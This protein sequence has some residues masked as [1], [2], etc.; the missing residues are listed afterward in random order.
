MFWEVISAKIKEFIHNNYQ[1]FL[2]GKQFFQ[3]LN[4]SIF[5]QEN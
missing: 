2:K 5:K 4:L 3:N 1:S